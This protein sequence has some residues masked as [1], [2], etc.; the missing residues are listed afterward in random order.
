MKS[1]HINGFG[2]F[3]ESEAIPGAL[4]LRNNTPQRAPLGLY[5]ELIS[6]TTFVAPRAQ[7]RRVH[8]YRIHPSV[9]QPTFSRMDNGLLLSGPFEQ[10]LNPNPFRW[11]PFEMPT[12]PTDFIDGL[13]TLCGNG[14]PKAQSGLAVHVYRANQSMSKRAFVNADGDMLFVPQTGRIELRTELGI[15]QVGPNEIALIPRGIK[16]AVKC[17]DGHA[18]GFVGETY[19]MPFQLPDLGVIGS[20]GLA[21]PSDFWAPVAA[22]EE[23]NQA[24]QLVHKYGGN[25]WVTE[26]AHSPFN[27]VAWRGNHV[28][29]KYD[30]V[31]YVTLGSISVDH[32]DPS[33]FTVLTSPSDKVG[34]ANMDFVIF[35]PRWSVAED[36]F[37]PPPFHRNVMSEF[38]GMIHGAHYSRSSGFEPGGALLHNCWVPHGPDVATYDKAYNAALVPQKLDNHLAFMF[39][40]RYPMHLTPF[41]LQAKELQKD[42]H[43]QWV[44]FPNHFSMQGKT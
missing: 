16:F 12:T 36:T 22:Y 13:S 15:L 26:V 1:T 10:D 6:G 11:D 43:Q 40:T 37:R 27:V 32:P 25:L 24:H 34:G 2:N 28:P 5:P 4:P 18:R 42:I 23:N 21:N 30:T 39:E 33:I 35:P 31:N 7:N 14:D 19:G 8:T 44:G 9:D 20:H 29:F 38:M 17:L 41:A 3:L